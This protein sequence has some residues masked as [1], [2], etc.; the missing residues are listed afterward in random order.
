MKYLLFILSLC[1]A[2]NAVKAQENI[3]EALAYQYFQQAEYAKAASLLEKLFNRSKN[4]SYFDLYFTSLLKIKKYDEAEVVVK[5]LIKQYPQKLNYQIALGR[6]YQENGKIAEA[7]KIY[8]TAIQNAPKSEFQYRELANA[9]YR[10]EAYDM[11]VNAFLQGRRTL[12]DEQLFTFELLSIYRFKKD[13]QALI[14][15][16]LNSLPNNPQLLPQAQSVLASLFE[17][18]SDYMLLQAALLKKLQKQPDAEIFTELLIWQYIQQK[19]YEMALRQLVAQDKRTNNSANLLFN[20]ANNLLANNAFSTAIKAYEYIVSKGPEYELYLPAKIQLINAKYE[21]AIQGK[22]DQQAMKTLE[23]EF[24]QIIAQY[25]I[26]NQT[27]F[28][29]KKLS[30]LQAY[31]LRN[32]SAAEKTLEQ[33]LKI[34]NL[35][36]AETAELKIE[37]GDIYILNKEPWEAILVYE[38]VAKQ[39]ENLPIASEARFR[40]AKLSFYQ[41]NFKYAKSQADVLKASTSQLIAN[42]AL[43][44]SLLISDN[45]QSKNDSLALAMYADAELLQFVNNANAALKKLDSIDIAYPKNSLTDD[46]LMAKAKIFIKNMEFERAEANLKTLIA[47]HATSIWID[48]AIFTLADLY[49]NKLNNADE[50]KKLYQRLITD[51]P[52]SILN[53]EARK[54]YRNMRGDNL[55]T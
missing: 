29:L 41:G 20:T 18:N 53:A 14:S 8:Y 50:A 39:F 37:L 34:N 21:L 11:A 49:E 42:D 17:D 30:S 31:Y 32:L 13:K 55:G 3:D 5:K 40:S 48:D 16:Y 54:R 7:N 27:V 1:F 22:T 4:D 52:G 23:G 9:F 2:F 51:Y 26:T 46:I 19:D 47:D 33:A 36:A 45:L 15:E 44:L 10:I 25:G 43:N 35:P 38:Q 24:M 6:I 28:A 12:G